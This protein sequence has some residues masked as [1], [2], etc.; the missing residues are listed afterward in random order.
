M[1]VMIVQLVKGIGAF[2]GGS[3]KCAGLQNQQTAKGGSRH[4]GWPNQQGLSPEVSFLHG[5][6]SR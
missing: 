3:G 4:A 6:C 1:H 2:A 5:S